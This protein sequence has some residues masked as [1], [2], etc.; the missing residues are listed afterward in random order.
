MDRIFVL[1]H[2]A[3]CPYCNNRLSI[4]AASGEVIYGVPS[5]RKPL[6]PCPH[7]TCF[8]I[9]LHVLRKKSDVFR[10]TTDNKQTVSWLWEHGRGI[11]A[12]NSLL[13]PE[14]ADFTHYLCD[15]SV[16]NIPRKLRITSPHEFIGAIADVREESEPGAARF[17]LGQEKGDLLV[18]GLDSFVIFAPKPA[19]VMKEIREL[20]NR[21]E[22]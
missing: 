3:D 21:Y 17:V 19:Q 9:L 1:K 20:V 13:H 15:Y 22:H 18:A 8:W 4:D 11:Y 16:N 6:P 14:H 5:V 7:L 2:I 12:V 10:S